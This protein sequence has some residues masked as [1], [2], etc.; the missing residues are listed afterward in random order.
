MR[1]KT[2]KFIAQLCHAM[3]WR[4]MQHSEVSKY[5]LISQPKLKQFQLQCYSKCST[6]W[7]PLVS[8]QQQR[9]L[10]HWSTV[11]STMLCCRPDHS[12]LLYQ[13]THI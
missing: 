4:T 6:N 2:E 11:S 10:R 5:R 9:Y 13:A 8:M 3:Q 7:W 12:H 1:N